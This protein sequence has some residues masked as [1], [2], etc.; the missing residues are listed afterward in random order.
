M[1]PYEL[2]EYKFAKGPLCN[3]LISNHLGN[4]NN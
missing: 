2:N 1:K 3:I 4:R